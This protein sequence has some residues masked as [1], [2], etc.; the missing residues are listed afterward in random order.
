MKICKKCGINKPKDAFYLNGD[1]SSYTKCKPCVN[2]YQKEM[3]TKRL[4]KKR[5][6]QDVGTKVCISCK[7]MKPVSEFQKSAL[8]KLGLSSN[9]K[10]CL[11]M[12]RQLSK[13]S[14]TSERYEDLYERQS[15]RCAIC[16]TSAV[17]KL[18]LVIDHDHSCCPDPNS[19]C[20]KCL[21]GLLC[22]SCNTGLGN[23]NDSIELLER[24][25]EFKSL[26][27]LRWTGQ[28]WARNH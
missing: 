4:K 21:R 24:A 26:G 20:G 19:S 3:R 10:K 14:L 16:E 9:C 18:G 28:N 23:L 12:S 11:R 2:A 5:P 17:S 25:A 8:M 22:S 13:H 6:V 7:E 27:Q 15:G 1:G